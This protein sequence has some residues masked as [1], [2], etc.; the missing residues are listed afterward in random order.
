MKII[1]LTLLFSFFFIT[2]NA[3][4]EKI[5]LLPNKSHKSFMLI[6][7]SKINILPAENYALVLPKYEFPN[8]KVPQ[9]F[10]PC[11]KDFVNITAIPNAC[12]NASKVFTFREIVVTK[13]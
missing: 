7:T 11:K 3:L 13:K 9:N 5:N 1:K 6:D 4:Q 2:A 8:L 12:P 10:M